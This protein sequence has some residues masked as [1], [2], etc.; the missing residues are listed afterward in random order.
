MIS[1]PIVAAPE[2]ESASV[3]QPDAECWLVVDQSPT[4]PRGLDELQVE[5]KREFGLDPFS[6]RQKLV[7][8]GY[9][10]FARGKG[11]RRFAAVQQ[12][13]RQA[14]IPC[15]LLQP[16]RPTVPLRKMQGLR[17]EPESVAL[18]ADGT[19]IRVRSET[20]VVAILADLSG[21]M[22]EKT[23]KRLLTRTAFQGVASL[24]ATEGTIRQEIV[25]GGR[26]VLDLY[27]L[28]QAGEVQ[29]S[30]R[31]FTARFDASGLGERMTPS[32]GLNLLALIDLLQEKAGRLVVRTDFGLANLP[33]CQLHP[34]GEQVANLA[35]LHR[36]GWLAARIAAI[37]APPSADAAAGAAILPLT[38]VAAAVLTPELAVAA[39]VLGQESTEPPSR[40]ATAEEVPPPATLPPAPPEE[41][42]HWGWGLGQRVRWSD[43][44]GGGVGVLLWL[45]GMSAGRSGESPLWHYGF[46]LGIIPALVAGYCLWQGIAALLLR[47][48]VVNTP[49]SKIRSLATGMVEISGRAVRSCALVSPVTHLPC[50]YYEL[51]RYRRDERNRWRMISRRSSGPVPFAVAD[52]TGRVMVDPRRAEL[53][54]GTREEGRGDGGG[55][56]FSGNGDSNEKWI[57]EVIPEGATVYV[58]GFAHVQRQHG[59][60]LRER[61]A[62]RLR[63]LKGSRE[64]VERFDRNGDGRVDQEEWE[65]ARRTIEDEASHAHLAEQGRR[66]RQ[67]EHLVVAAPPRR[68]LPFIVAQSLDEGALLRAFGWRAAA[69]FCAAALFMG[70]TLSRLM[71]YLSNNLHG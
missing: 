44:V 53:R 20:T 31:A 21:E 52:A 64:L 59:P 65:E 56:L 41:E 15:V 9:N 18:I 34:Q 24:A 45:L 35:A 13:L 23:L 50:V 32:A 67:E 49:A 28:D 63:D 22:A 60:S 11:G 69:Y 1:E 4:P 54:P 29:Q 58:L 48:A 37:P 36:F 6:V 2:E 43:L 68:G 47:R 19:E 46:G 8:R 71:V 12:L 40:P 10:L 70:W 61:T 30:V 38:G 25:K 57:E 14:G 3:P 55:L 5:L 7:G 62:A 17:V 42:S 51:R 27:L 66:K 16:S 39:A 26:A 33:G